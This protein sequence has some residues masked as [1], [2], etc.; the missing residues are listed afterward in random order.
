MHLSERVSKLDLVD[1]VLRLA[2]LR[3]RLRFAD[4][5]FNGFRSM[6]SLSRTAG[7]SAAASR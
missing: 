5:L 6:A 2:P 3:S 4:T 7:T 1:P